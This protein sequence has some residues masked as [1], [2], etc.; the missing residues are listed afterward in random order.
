[1][2][3]M[4]LYASRHGNTEKLARAMADAL[5][6]HGSARLLPVEEAPATLAA[7]LDL[8]I[9]GG[10]TEGH[11]MT[12]PMT[13]FFDKVDASGLRG[14]AAATF[15]TRLRG[16]RWLWGSA[17]AGIA[18][19]LRGLGVRVIAEPESFYVTGPMG[20][21]GGVPALLPDELE[22]ARNWAAAVAASAEL[23]SPVGV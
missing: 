2:N 23:M 15:D 21:E 5:Q 9:V 8:V 4:V 14:V 1:M 20:L 6:A 16:P 13:R 17:A 18:D 7:D 11:R 22:H 10:P 3:S 19:R 12:E